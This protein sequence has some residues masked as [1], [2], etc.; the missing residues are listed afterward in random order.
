MESSLVKVTGSEVQ[1][2]VEIGRRSNVDMPSRHRMSL[3]IDRVDEK[4]IRLTRGWGITHIEICDTEVLPSRN[5]GI[6]PNVT[7]FKD[8]SL[9]N[10]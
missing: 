2:C 1:G 7:N 9:L 5:S 6:K 8:F 10:L 4:N 3:D